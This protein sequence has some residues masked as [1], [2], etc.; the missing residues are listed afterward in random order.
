[1][2]A[3]H[4]DVHVYATAFGNPYNIKASTIVDVDDDTKLDEILDI[5]IGQLILGSSYKPKE[6]FADDNGSVIHGLV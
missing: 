4:I 6:Q 1:M 5:P 2:K 3:F